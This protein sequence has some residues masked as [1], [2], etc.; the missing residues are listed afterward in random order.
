MTRFTGRAVFALFM[1]GVIVF[2]V[3]LF[4]LCYRFDNKYTA[5]GPVAYNGMLALDEQTLDEFPVIFL[6]H[7]WEIYR[8]RLL[9]PEAFAAE[10]R[11][12]EYV[13]IGQ[14][15][16][17]E[18]SDP[19]RSPHGSATYRLS[20]IIPPEP[21][22]YTLE[23]PEVY[24]AYTL[25][26]NGV[27]AAQFGDPDP[28]SY[29]PKTGNS[30]VSFLARNRVEIIIAASDFS[31]I[32]S[33]VVYP[34]AFGLPQAV[35]VMIQS[36]LTIR[37]AVCAV[38]VV[39]AL[40][41]ISIGFL[42]KKDRT[43]LL[44]G[45]VC[46]SFAGYICY[47]VVKTIFHGGTGWYGF[48]NFCFCVMLLLV[49]FLQRTVTGDKSR[50]SN[51]FAA[52]GLFACLC[53][54]LRIALPVGDLRLLAAYSLL[55]GIYKWAAAAYLTISVIRTMG[56]S[57]RYGQTVLAGVLV[58]DCGLVMDRLL[59]AFEPVLFGWFTEIGGFAIVVTLCIVMAQEALRQYSQKLELEGRVA[60]VENLVQMQRAYYPVILEGIEVARHAR[61]D[62]RHHIGVLQGLIFSGKFD[63]SE[64]YLRQ[65]SQGFSEMT[66]LTWCENDVADVILRHFA[67]LSE[68]EGVR[69]NVDAAIP[70]TLAIDNAD[71]CIVLSN[72]LEN[73]L[74]A[75]LYV[76][77]EK[78]ISVTVKQYRN[79]LV[80]LV[81][82]SFDGNI[83]TRPAQG[84]GSS[85]LYMSR[86]RRNRKGVGLASVRAIAEKYN[87]GAELTPD[88]G[89][90]IFRSEV[91][92]RCV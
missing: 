48:E 14:Y 25:Y 20:I 37:T 66:P 47:P 26:I 92:M 50:L 81:D 41:F 36:R 33:G 60:G 86:K 29:R 91:I 11:P 89:K 51:I 44:F 62:L 57:P 5:S 35:S 68:R 12:D 46:L 4:F 42:S 90:K 80:I 30:A 34:P 38:A 3:A 23:L 53:S 52:A 7:G 67:A 59:P 54:L 22:A 71:L 58:F 65:Y 56:A 74:E 31:H 75:C 2:S 45:A 8:D 13:F 64:Q 40:L 72:L 6:T 61:H 88:A 10:S 87:G 79:E 43:M 16:G 28:G 32:Y 15:G 69:F 27:L 85:V 77:E 76:S 49:I 83:R 70:E 17:F 1:A 84:D 21:A 63:E 78:L 82:N 73:A 39:M 18:G 9:S 19:R 55:I 24:S